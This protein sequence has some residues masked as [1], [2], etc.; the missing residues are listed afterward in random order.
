MLSVGIDL[1]EI[2]RIEK[3][4]GSQ[5]FVERVYGKS[6]RAEFARRPNCASSMAAAFAAKEAFSKAIGTGIRG[7]SLREVELL[8]DTLGAPYLFLSGKAADIA[9]G[10]SL[11]FCVSV[12]HTEHYAS[13]VVIAEPA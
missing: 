3:S 4:V 10:R 8:H 6:E 12:T 2:G 1:V 11:R 9:A 5:R 7:F 13:A